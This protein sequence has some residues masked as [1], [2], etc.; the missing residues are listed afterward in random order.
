MCNFNAKTQILQTSQYDFW[1]WSMVNGLQV[2]TVC[3]W[4]GKRRNANC[5]WAHWSNPSCKFSRICT[6]GS[7]DAEIELWSWVLCGLWPTVQHKRTSETSTLLHSAWQKY[8]IYTRIVALNSDKYMAHTH[9][10]LFIRQC[11]NYVLLVFFISEV[12]ID[13]LQLWLCWKSQVVQQTVQNLTALVITWK[14]GV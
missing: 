6:A 14:N 7:S 2:W 10:S 5:Y 9:T 12:L 13:Y 4:R 3:F 1:H 8:G 11:S